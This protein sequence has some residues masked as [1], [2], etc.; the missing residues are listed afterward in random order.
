MF[1]WKSNFNSQLFNEK[2]FYSRFI[3]D[4]ENSQKEVIIESPYL[5]ASRMTVLYPIFQVLLKRRV[6]IHIV[7]RDPIDHDDEYLRHQATN[8]LLNSMELGINII[9][10]QGSH[11]R[12]IAI[13]DR[14]ILWEGSLNILSYFK[15]R[16]VM[17]RLA[18]GNHAINMFRFLKLNDLL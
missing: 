7:T 5:T 12:K 18:G 6:K 10:L 15:S 11:H 17:R 16:E 13:I 9:L 3:K 2:I 4:L 14:K 1:I 8:E